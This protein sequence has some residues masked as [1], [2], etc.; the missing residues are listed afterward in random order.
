MSEIPVQPERERAMN[1]LEATRAQFIEMTAGRTPAQ[2]R[3]KPAGGERWSLGELAEH[4]AVTERGVL[5]SIRRS[6]SG[7]SATAEEK[8]ATSGRDE[9][10][11]RGLPDRS[12]KVLAPEAVRPM[13]RFAGLAQTVEEF[14]ARREE[15]MRLLETTEN[16]LLRE[17]VLPHPVLGPLDVYQ[18]VLFLAAHCDRHLQQMKEVTADPDFPAELP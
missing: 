4:L 10:L 5:L 14:K 1:Y 7:P 18:W 15:T 8:A 2:W 9:R 16:D 12:R 13:G 6:L 11:L 3:F 17:H